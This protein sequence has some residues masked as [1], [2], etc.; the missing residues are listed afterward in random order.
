MTNEPTSI[1]DKGIVSLNP[2][3]KHVNMHRFLWGFT[4]VCGF[5]AWNKGIMLLYVMVA[6]LLAVILLSYLYRFF[7]LKGIEVSKTMPNIVT[8]GSTFECDYHVSSAGRKHLIGLQDSIRP[9]N[10]VN[11]QYSLDAEEDT[12]NKTLFFTQIKEDVLVKESVYVPKRGVY[13]SDSVQ[14]SCSYPFGI[15]P[16]CIKQPIDPKKLYVLPAV[17]SIQSMDALLVNQDSHGN[18]L[19]LRTGSGDELSEIRPYRKGDE[20]KHIHWSATAK[21]M[22]KNQ[23]WMSK[24]F[25]S[26]SHPSF[27]MVLNQFDCRQENLE[28]MLSIA[29]SIAHHTSQHGFQAYIIGV[30]QLPSTQENTKKIA[31]WHIDVPILDAYLNDNLVPLSQ[32]TPINNHTGAQTP[33]SKTD[34]Y[35]QLIQSYDDLIHHAQSNFVATN[36]LI[37]FGMYDVHIASANYSHIH[38]KFSQHAELSK[39]IENNKITHHIPTNTELATLADL[40]ANKNSQEYFG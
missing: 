16:H 31:P 17:F 13:V 5:I 15:L 6:F 29:S 4:L 38:F 25:Q 35:M 40:F 1:L 34:D 12:L 20:F 26:S 10:E 11:A 18:I 2:I 33:A 28:L 8:A 30:N 19:S 14:L 24:S 32:V 36:V 9:I 37:S 27:L 7:N 22:S 39:N 3:L 21:Q 23:P